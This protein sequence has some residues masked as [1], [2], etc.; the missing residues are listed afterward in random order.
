MMTPHAEAAIA[1]DHE[2]GKYKLSAEPGIGY[3]YRWDSNGD[4]QFETPSFGDQLSIDVELARTER[5]TVTLQVRDIFGR[6]ATRKFKL[7]RPAEEQ[8]G[9]RNTRT[10]NNPDA[11]AQ[12]KDPSA[13]GQNEL[14]APSHAIQPGQPQ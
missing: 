13:R 14:N 4:G 8:L 12:P 10:N 7:E 5:R 11:A 1:T 2:T 9:P 6:E 3:G